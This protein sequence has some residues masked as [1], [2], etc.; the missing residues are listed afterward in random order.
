MAP[1]RVNEI[2]L[3]RFLAALSVVF[4]HYTFRGYAA[5]GLSSMPFT[6]LSPFAKYGYLGVELF[7]LI[8][9]FVV[10]MTAEAARRVRDFAISRIVRL[11]PAYWACCTITCAAILA[12][13]APTQV[14]TLD[15]YL[16]NMTMLTGL[17]KFQLIDGAYWSLLVEIRFY[18]LVAVLLAV[19]KI[20]Q[21]QRFLVIWL[22][23]TI[24][25]ELLPILAQQINWVPPDALR[26]IRY[27]L[28]VNY[29]AYFIAGATCYLLWSKGATAG[30]IC[31]ITACWVLALYQAKPTLGEFEAYYK[32]T[33]R[34]DIV[35]GIITIFFLIMVIIAMRKTGS[36]ARYRWPMAG[37]ISY[38]LYLIHQNIGYIILNHFHPK[39]SQHL[40]LWSTL[41][42]VLLAS[43]LVHRFVEQRLSLKLKTVLTARLN[44][45]AWS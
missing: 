31:I 17:T 19:G 39:V 16:V 7:F 15:Q 37:A 44:H 36:L 9:G 6:W 12:F 1:T 45:R 30:K 40:L 26:Y 42:F 4:Y 23:A 8:S 43:Y 29:S 35:F 10:L 24:S 18:A 22:V 34:T 41:I 25:L 21:A 27:L 38:P 2:D 5:D 11:Y 13:G 32:T 28:I 33:I 20:H 14:I 3:L